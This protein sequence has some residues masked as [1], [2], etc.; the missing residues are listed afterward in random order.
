[1]WPDR[2]SSPGALALES[3]SLLTEMRG[4]TQI[5]G[6][7]SLCETEPLSLCMITIYFNDIQ[8]SVESVNSRYLKH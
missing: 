8:D 7:I 6:G 2:V 1:M 4:P 5:V 3:D